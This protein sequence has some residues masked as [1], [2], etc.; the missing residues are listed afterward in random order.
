MASALERELDFL[1]GRLANDEPGSL[2]LDQKEDEP[3]PL[4]LDQ[5]NDR[6][7]SKRWLSGKRW[8]KRPSLGKRSSRALIPYLITASYLIP[9][10]IGVAVTLAWKSYGTPSTDQE[11]AAVRQSVDQ[12]R[13]SVDQLTARV[14]QISGDIAA[15]Q[16]ILRRVS[17]PA[18][19][20]PP[21]LRRG[22]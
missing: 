21:A 6:L 3:L 7:S 2:G 1:L 10:C 11:L 8:I 13:Q 22:N 18:P 14:Q 12:V 19:P 20:A 16:A 15:Q 5:K 4:G 9:L 17:A